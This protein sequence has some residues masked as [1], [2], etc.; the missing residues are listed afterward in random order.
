ML[1]AER[2]QYILNQLT[3][4]QSIKVLD[5]VSDLKCSPATIRRDLDVLEKQ[6][7]LKRVHGGAIL[8]TLNQDSLLSERLEHNAYDKAQVAQFVRQQFLQKEQC[9]FLD[10][11]SSTQHIIPFLDA[12][13]HQVI[14]NGIHHLSE[15]V[16]LNI[17]TLLIGGRVKSSTQATIGSTATQQLQQYHFDIAL[18]GVNSIDS[19]FGLSTPDSE[20]AI[21]KQTVIKQSR[22]AIVL[23]DFSKFDTQSFHQFALMDQ[24]KI[25]TMRCP[26]TYQ[27][28]T[29]VYCLKPE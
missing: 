16:A 14:T 26:V 5:V 25:V 11:G 21:I 22:Q 12:R 27:H 3:L 1:S 6:H 13:K 24:V 8:P 18:L 2:Y 17:P 19:T 10:A 7:K 28:M 9:I 4:H 23:A 29:N 20:E 15:L